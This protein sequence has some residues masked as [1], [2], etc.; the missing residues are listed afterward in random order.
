MREA[1]GR[2]DRERGQATKP[3]DGDGDENV[4]VELDPQRFVT[5]PEGRRAWLREG[6]R[7]LDAERE[8]RRA[9]SRS[10][11][12]DRLFEACR[13]LEQEL[14]V[15][16]AQNAAYEAWRA[17]GVAADET[18]RMA[19]GMLK[20]YQPPVASQRLVNVTDHDSRAVRTQGQSPLQGYNRRWR[21]TTSSS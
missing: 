19:P 13:R 9:R 1:K 5:R 20:P 8:S 15:D 11:G 18:H 17:R 12:T 6:R 21:S 16:H 3:A 4:A 2:L 7:T 14:D 10:S